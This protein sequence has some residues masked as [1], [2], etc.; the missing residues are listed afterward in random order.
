M[1]NQDIPASV[2]VTDARRYE[3]EASFGHA[4]SPRRAYF[5]TL[6]ELTWQYVTRARDNER[7]RREIPRITLREVG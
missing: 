1:S 2:L 4:S 7:A 6:A 5:I 3:H